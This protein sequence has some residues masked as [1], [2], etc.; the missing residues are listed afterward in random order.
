VSDDTVVKTATSPEDGSTAVSAPPT[1]D[2]A[3]NLQTAPPSSTT[4]GS[5]STPNNTTVDP[6]TVPNDTPTQATVTPSRGFDAPSPEVTET[7]SNGTTATTTTNTTS[8]AVPTSQP[9]LK[10]S[11]FPLDQVSELAL[12]P[13]VLFFAGGAF[14][15]LLVI[16]WW[17]WHSSGTES[18]IHPSMVLVGMLVVAAIVGT[19][20]LLSGF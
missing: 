20:V 3:A 8:T 7:I 6:T 17:Y 10:S 18:R 13:G 15:F 9:P 5:T 2:R 1:S 19:S 4:V 16:L 11:I 12:S 14:V